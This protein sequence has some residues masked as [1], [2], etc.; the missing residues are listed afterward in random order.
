MSKRWAIA[1]VALVTLPILA[2]SAAFARS[3]PARTQ[4]DPLQF[5]GRWSVSVITNSGACDRGY[6]YRL[7]IRNGQIS[8]DN[9][10]VQVSGQVTPRG[11]VQVVVRAGGQQAVGF[12]R[13]SP[14]YGEGSWNG[15]SGAGQCSGVW[16]AQRAGS[17]D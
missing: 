9:P 17:S 7:D 14:D 3:Q 15:Q 11:Q 6:R 10:A 4:P 5:D 1:V 8:Y 12:G 2:G 13:M 16:Q